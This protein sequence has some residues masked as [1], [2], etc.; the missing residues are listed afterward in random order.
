MTMRIAN[1]PMTV[2]LASPVWRVGWTKAQ[3]VDG[4]LSTSRTTGIRFFALRP[5]PATLEKFAETHRRSASGANVRDPADTRF[6]AHLHRSWRHPQGRQNVASCRRPY[7]ASASHLNNP[8]AGASR[9]ER[10]LAD[11]LVDGETC[12]GAVVTAI[13]GGFRPRLDPREEVADSFQIHLAR[14][15]F[16]NVMP[17]ARNDVR[18]GCKGRLQLPLE[19]LFR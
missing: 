16:R 9:K 2:T 5:A 1:R 4:P 18:R 3:D 7:G 17:H 13:S 14:D 11:G 15:G 6:L 8:S 19:H 12:T 10:A